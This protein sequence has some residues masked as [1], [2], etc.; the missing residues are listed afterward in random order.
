MTK[1][2]SY[3]KYV[4][5]KFKRKFVGDFD[6]MYK[7]ENVDP[8]YCSDFSTDVKKIHLAILGNYNFNNILDYGCGN[9][10]FTHIL[11][12]NN[13]EVSGVDISRNA[14][15]KAKLMY[16][17]LVDFSTL[18]EKK[19]QNRKFDLI[20]CL[21]VLSYVK[22]YKQLLET[23][24]ITGS[25]LYLSL[26]IPK[27]PIGY[28]KNFEKLIKQINFFIRSI[29]KLYIMMKSFFYLQNQINIQSN[30]GAL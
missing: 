19:W 27:N 30:K 20:V 12:K 16:G 18:E 13:N 6:N 23:F 7:K 15:N 5:N 24:S 26:Y 25:H 2:T 3:Q 29:V 14:I 1:K 28:V 4:F 10:A 8:W 9:G 17:H 22:Q 21:E 11:K